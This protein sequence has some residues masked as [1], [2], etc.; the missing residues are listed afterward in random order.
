MLGFVLPLLLYSFVFVLHLVLP[1]RTVDGYVIDPATSRP[2]R[3]RLNGLGVFAVTIALYVFAAR[4]G[5]IAWDLFWT[6]RWQMAAGACAPRPRLHARDRAA[7]A[8][9]AAPSAP[10]CTSAAS[11]TRSGSAAASTPRCS[12]TSSAR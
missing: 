11:R 3:Y 12:S 9:R 6:Y 2:L 10:T 1:A 7:G 8:A 5:F 4:R